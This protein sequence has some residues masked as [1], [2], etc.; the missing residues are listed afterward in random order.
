MAIILKDNYSI[1]LPGS[2]A[3]INRVSHQSE[4]NQD[5]PCNPIKNLL[6]LV[7][8]NLHIRQQHKQI[9]PFGITSLACTYTKSTLTHDTHSMQLAT[10]SNPG[11]KYLCVLSA[12]LRDKHLR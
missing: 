9:L 2:P 5:C 10:K 7:F 3:L 11:V 12:G 8:L 1:F 4:M 6:Y